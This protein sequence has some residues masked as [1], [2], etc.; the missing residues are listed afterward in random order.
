MTSLIFELG[1]ERALAVYRVLFSLRCDLRL[2]LMVLVH[3]ERCNLRTQG[4][5]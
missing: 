4:T 2:L 1:N 5:H 3:S